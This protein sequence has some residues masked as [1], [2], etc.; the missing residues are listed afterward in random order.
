MSSIAVKISFA[1]APA[2]RFRAKKALLHQEN[3]KN[4]AL[5]KRSQFALDISFAQEPYFCAK[6]PYDPIKEPYS[7][8]KEPYISAKEP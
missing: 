1:K 5:R 2:K 8:A 6:R 7:F 3:S 4:R